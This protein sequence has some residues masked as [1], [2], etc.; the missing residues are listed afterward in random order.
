MYFSLLLIPYLTLNRSRI[1]AWVENP[2]HMSNKMVDSSD[3][4]AA[5][6]AVAAIER[7]SPIREFLLM[8][9]NILSMIFCRS[10]ISLMEPKF[11]ERRFEPV[12]PSALWINILS[13]RFIYYLILSITMSL[14]E[15]WEP[16]EFLERQI[17][18][19]TRDFISILSEPE[20]F[21]W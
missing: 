5:T 1:I 2:V 11:L 6:S 10:P 9:K 21:S 15:P 16:E 17:L 7:K 3:T 4:S 13:N 14:M 12:R 20:S 18:S 8:Q 19:F